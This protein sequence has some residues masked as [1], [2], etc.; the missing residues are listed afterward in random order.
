[1]SFAIFNKLHLSHKISIVLLKIIASPIFVTLKNLNCVEVI[2]LELAMEL[3]EH[4]EMNNHTIHL[5]EGKQPPYE[6]IYS[7]ESLE[8]KSLKTYIKSSLANSFIRLFKSVLS[9]SILFVQKPNGGLCLCINYQDLNNLTIKNWYPLP[10]I[11]EFLNWPDWAK[12]LA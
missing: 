3:P 6:R 5:I 8:L 12:Q 1:M 10:L 2:F 4:R 9:V 11:N 7:L